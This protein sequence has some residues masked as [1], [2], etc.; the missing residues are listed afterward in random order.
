MLIDAV[1]SGDVLRLRDHRTRM[2]VSTRF[3]DTTVLVLLLVVVMVVN[4]PSKT[5][6][7]DNSCGAQCARPIFD[8]RAQQIDTVGTPIQALHTIFIVG[9]WA[10]RAPAA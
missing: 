6:C 4:W 8:F 5:I 7:M 1:D 10:N 3:A 9:P 2:Y